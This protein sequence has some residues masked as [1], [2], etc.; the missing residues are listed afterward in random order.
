MTSTRVPF[1]KAAL[2]K[3]FEGLTGVGASGV[4]VLYAYKPD[5]ERTSVWFG[6]AAFSE[7]DIA[8]FRAGRPRRYENFTLETY[9]EARGRSPEDSE[10]KAFDISAAIEQGLADDPKLGGIEG[11]T[12][13]LV[14]SIESD[15]RDDGQGHFTEIKLMIRCK[16]HFV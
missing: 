8:T 12:F 5:R 15:T 6:E 10:L 2:K 7:L 1:V 13:A 16:G 9:I 11:L 3:K 4:Q 14:E